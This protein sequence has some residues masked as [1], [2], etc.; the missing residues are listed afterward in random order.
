MHHNWFWVLDFSSWIFGF[1]SSE[2]YLGHCLMHVRFVQFRWTHNSHRHTST[3][4]AF[5]SWCWWEM[6]TSSIHTCETGI[7]IWA[8]YN[9]R[10][11]TVQHKKNTGIVV[12]IRGTIFR[13]CRLNIILK[14]TL[15]IFVFVTHL[16]KSWSVASQFDHVSSRLINLFFNSLYAMYSNQTD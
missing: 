15:F 9:F 3:C 11:F 7:E 8:F 10:K 1:D 5:N 16:P 13:C 6:F 12:L 14:L 4:P 2:R